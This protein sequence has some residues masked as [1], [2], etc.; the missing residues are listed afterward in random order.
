MFWIYVE[1]V[2]K[3]NR[4]VVTLQDGSSVES[5]NEKMYYEP[6]V[7]IVSPEGKY[8]GLIGKT[9]WIKC[10]QEKRLV[11]NTLAK[12]IL[13]E[14]K[15]TRAKEIFCA[16]PHIKNIP[17]IDSDSKIICEYLRDPLVDIVEKLRE[18][19][20]KIGDNVNIYDFFIDTSW[21]F[22][23]EIGNRVTISCASVLA[24][25]ASIM[26][27][28]KVGRVIIG[29]D[30]FIGYRSIILPNVRIGNKVIV[31]AGSV[32]TKDIPDNSVAAGNPA[33]VVGTFNEYM[34]KN[35]E[36]MENAK[37]FDL[38]RYKNGRLSDSL[39]ERM[40]TDIGEGEVGYVLN[41]KK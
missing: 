16:Y 35:K 37:V 23:I 14:G 19:G 3:I 31:G 41:V 13:G 32:V 8:V 18:E 34:K 25:D 39:K 21:G 22:L 26:C 15:E 17:V 7:Y 28:S 11:V 10:R 1:N 20:V 4:E 6:H 30:V 12:Y 2:M 33:R 38:D 9:E 36:E 29:N 27:G 40:D 5:L 24:H